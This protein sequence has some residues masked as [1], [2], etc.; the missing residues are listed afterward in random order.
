MALEHKSL[1]TVTR[2]A[3]VGPDTLPDERDD[4]RWSEFRYRTL[5]SMAP[6]FIFEYRF[7]AAGR[8][9]AV[10]ASDG[11]E[12][13]LG[14]TLEETERLGGWDALVDDAWKPIARARQ[15]RL[16]QGEPQSGEVR[17]CSVSGDRKWLQISL[18]PVRDPDTQVVIGVVGS[19][20]DITTRKVAEEAL[21]KSEA[22][23][24]AVTENTP[25]WLFLLDERLC[26]QFMNRPFGRNRP[27]IVRGCPFLDFVPQELRPSM[28]EIYRKALLEGVPGRLEL[29]KPGPDGTPGTFEHR[30]MPVID[31]GVVRSLT[32]AVTD[33]TERK[34]AESELR[35]Q[36]RILET[37][38]EGVILIDPSNHAIRLTNP[39]FE[40][41]FGYEPNELLGRSIEPLFSMLTAQRR[42]LAR[43]LGEGCKTGE[44]VPV[45]FECARRN[46]SRFVAACVVTP[47]NINGSEHWLA[48]LNDVTER[49]QLEREIIEIANREQQRIGNDLH[50]GLGQEL[51]GIALMLKG[52]ASQLRRE[53]S[54]ASSDVEEVIGLVNNA[55]ENTR[56]LARGLSPLG[57]GRRSLGAAIQ[58]LAARVSERFGVQVDCN[59]DFKEPLRLSETA[60]THV[61]RIVQEALTNVVRHSGGTEASITLRTSDEELHLR[62]DDNGQGFA[63]TLPERPEG[64]GLKIM[65]YRAQT[66]GGDLSIGSAENSGV[67]VRFSCPLDFTV[68]E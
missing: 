4:L 25:D 22:V 16:R 52:V 33:I 65:R 61:Y 56:T 34:R 26:V 36:A 59:L 45:E 40:R 21:R 10:W 54:A 15:A 28:E 64:M 9:E 55:I 38:R 49:K 48:V 30:I 44:P 31:S 11:V 14:C 66:L 20:Y 53:G 50:D 7:N 46:G 47:V 42:R 58:T 43:A 6:G 3:G 12:A 19:A 13:V 17:V 8:P 32:V 51:T 29:R 5:A 62:V 35:M 67:S 63:Q 60:A 39:T 27:D 23:L 24:R 2:Y 57:S 41:M 37:M 1:D 18:Q 68:D